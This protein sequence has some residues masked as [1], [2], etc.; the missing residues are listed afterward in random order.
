MFS[1]VTC[2]PT[3][4]HHTLEFSLLK[5]ILWFIFLQKVTLLMR[6]SCYKNQSINL[7]GIAHVGKAYSRNRLFLEHI[8]PYWRELR[9]L[10]TPWVKSIKEGTDPWKNEKRALLSQCPASAPRTQCL[11]GQVARFLRPFEARPADPVR[12]KLYRQLAE[13][14]CIAATSGWVA[15]SEALASTPP[16]LGPGTEEY[17]SRAL[18][19]KK[20]RR[21]T[22]N[23]QP[24]ASG[25]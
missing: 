15:P 2:Y 10:V 1:A 24:S 12:R 11:G 5:C 25:N 16:P 14:P 8:R 22:S 3:S 7:I 6:K 18:P 19:S 21:R 17:A 23:R 20:K 13:E 4:W 9:P